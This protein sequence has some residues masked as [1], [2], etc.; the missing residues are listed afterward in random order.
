MNVI[1]IFALLVFFIAFV[2]SRYQS[3]RQYRAVD[4]MLNEILNGQE[5]SLPDLQEGRISALASKARQI[6]EKMQADL[7]REQEE[8]EQ[9]KSLISNMSHQLKTPLAGLMM[10]L[11][12]LQEQKIEGK[13]Q[14]EIFGRMKKQTEKIDWVLHSLLKMIRLEQGAVV[15]EACDCSVRK[16]LMDAVNSIYEKAEQKEIEIIMEPFADAMLYHNNKW[17]AEAFENIFENAIKYTEPEGRIFVRVIPMD[18]YTQIQI[19]DTGIGI[20]QEELVYIFKR[21]YRSKDVEHKEGTGIGL[22]LTRMILEK[23]KGYITASSRPG[24][25][26][27]F[28]VFLQNCHN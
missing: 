15:F 19:E 2:C 4:K 8:N 20:Q 27:C 10:Y 14:K 22:Y 12:I 9:V 3:H 1:W 21:F 11:E 25:G 6:Q 7:S 26:S 16:T 28:C 17:T 24:E 23:E 13:K 5:I 18:L